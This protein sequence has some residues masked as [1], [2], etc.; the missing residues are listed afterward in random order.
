MSPRSS[1]PSSPAG[2]VAHGFRGDA[3][4]PGQLV[5]GAV[6]LEDQLH[7][8]TLVGGEGVKAHGAGA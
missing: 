6:L 5:V 1:S 4:Q 3:Q 7:H 8:R 2:A